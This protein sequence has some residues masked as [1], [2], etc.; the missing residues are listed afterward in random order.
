MICGGIY[1]IGIGIGIGIFLFSSM[2]Y[3]VEVVCLFDLFRFV[4]SVSMIKMKTIC[5]F[6]GTVGLFLGDFIMWSV[7]T[8]IC[9][10]V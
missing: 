5:I 2:L 1:G 4:S 10:Y 8:A 9:S 3:V 6:T 7:F